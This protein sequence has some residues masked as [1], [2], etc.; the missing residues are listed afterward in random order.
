MNWMIVTQAATAFYLV[1]G[2]L[3]IDAS[4]NFASKVIF[5]VIPMLLGVSLAFG[6][7]AQ[8]KGI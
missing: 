3:V 1:A 6:V 8:V 4:S 7:F 2:S 5:K